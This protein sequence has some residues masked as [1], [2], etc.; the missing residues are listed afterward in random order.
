MSEKGLCRRSRRDAQPPIQSRSLELTTTS[1][2]THAHAQGE[3]GRDKNA[4]SIDRTHRAHRATNQ[5]PNT[6][7]IAQS[8]SRRCRSIDAALSISHTIKRRATAA[9]SSP[10]KP[11]STNKS[12][13]NKSGSRESIATNANNAIFRSFPHFSVSTSRLQRPHF[14][15]I[16]VCEVDRPRWIATQ[17]RSQANASNAAALSLSL[18]HFPSISP[19]QSIHLAFVDSD[20]DCRCG[21]DRRFAT[22]PTHRLPAAAA[23]ASRSRRTS[24]SLA[25]AA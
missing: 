23:P 21:M 14:A 17:S 9:A 2:C 20:S 6:H 12:S 22:A 1:R 7:S 3:R 15:E 25:A 16:A 13:S 19:N 24:S 11:V 10:P 18:A 5:P 4:A 8:H